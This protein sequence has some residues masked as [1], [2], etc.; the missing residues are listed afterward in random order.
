VYTSRS[1][2]W[3]LSVT[4]TSGCQRRH[5]KCVYSVCVCVCV[6]PLL[7]FEMSSGSL[8]IPR[9]VNQGGVQSL[10]HKSTLYET[11]TVE[12]SLTPQK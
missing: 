3:W 7:S 6:I 2:C 12:E 4:M 11:H 9:H 10:P 8:F 5:G 1:I